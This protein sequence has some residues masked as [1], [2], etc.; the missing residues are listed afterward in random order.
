MAALLLLNT[1]CSS[2]LNREYVSVTPHV[3]ATTAEG[4]VSVLRAESY[5]ELVNALMFFILQGAETGSI[6]MYMDQDNVE[7]NLENAC[8]EVV[9]EDPLGA[10]AVEHITHSVTPV[11]TYSQAEVQITYRRTKDQ[12]ASIISATGTSAIRNELKS[13][14]SDFAPACTLR[15]SYF[16]GNE[17]YILSLVREAYYSNPLT[18]QGFPNAQISIYPNSGRQRIVE[19]AL[20]YPL[21]LPELEL[22]RDRL[23]EEQ[24][25]L[26]A[27]DPRPQD[28]ILSSVRTILDAGGYLPQ[29]GSTAYHALLEGGANSEGLALAMAL[30][31]QLRHVS[32]QVVCGSLAQETHFWNVVETDSGWRHLDL[33]NPDVLDSPYASDT[34]MRDAGYDW[35]SASVPQCGPTE[36]EKIAIAAANALNLPANSP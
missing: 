9:H 26:T 27:R 14:L 5:Q 13:A 34:A 33:S 6:R 21:E 22:H 36:S 15:I 19:I 1:G 12:V 20:H 25:Y 17:D 10:Y 4:D 23:A 11:V 24:D 32:C 2:L 29:G 16:D 30:L 35:D 3:N 7:I 31:C 28:P 18:A 8:L